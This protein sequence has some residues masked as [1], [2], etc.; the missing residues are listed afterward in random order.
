MASRTV[1]PTGG[2]AH[3]RPY[4]L[5]FSLYW[6]WTILCFRS[7][8]AFSPDIGLD[9]ILNIRALFF[10]VS[11]ITTAA[12][13]PVCGLLVVRL[14][15]AAP[16][17]WW[18]CAAGM[19]LSVGCV[20]LA[21]GQA[22]DATAIAAGIVSGATSAYLDVCW[23][24]T[25]GRLHPKTS[26][27]YIIA[28]LAIAFAGFFA[29]V[30]LSRL[31][32]GIPIAIACL[33][34]FASALTL[35]LD[36]N[37]V[38]REGDVSQDATESAAGESLSH[39]AAQIARVLWR[40]ILGSLVFFF[41]DGC[42]GAI[43]PIT[44]NLNEYGTVSIALDLVATVALLAVLLAFKRVSI[45]LTYSVAMILVTTG[46]VVLPF[47][48]GVL[49]LSQTRLA[50]ASAL[51]GSGM[52]LFDLLILCMIAQCAYD[53]RTPGAMVCGVVRGVTVGM[54]AL[55][56]LLGSWVGPQIE[57]E[58]MIVV[59]LTVGALYLLVLSTTFYLGR[60]RSKGV[61]LE[62]TA[63]AG[64]G[65]RNLADIMD[66]REGGQAT[67]PAGAATPGMQGGQTSGAASDVAPAETLAD[68]T[69]SRIQ[70]VS[71]TYHLSRRETDV[72]A[73]LAQ[74][75]SIPYIAETLVISENTVRSH[76]QRIYA[77]L[78]VHSKQQLL[79]LVQGTDDGR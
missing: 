44:D 22:S 38:R 6:V 8:L 9:S 5:G 19:A 37:A 65:Q 46:F 68:L 54:I 28:S 51:I 20:G 50:L 24:Q 53:W 32:A 4:L 34:P 16:A 61:L 1:S 66:A 79:D 31:H 7:T 12:F 48:L 74:G 21:Q 36:R 10:A 64:A 58:S 11:L 42:L 52:N 3:V 60:R 78:D 67:P 15:R 59:L 30:P 41:A 57:R 33:L 69:A 13:H 63:G 47:G 73:L 75:R 70:D 62:E 25:Y 14:R 77:K 35:Q 39:N 43:S 26:G 71:H 29:L 18:A 40:P 56:H 27:R 76:A 2:V 45:D 17:L 55:G 72:F 49:G 23:A